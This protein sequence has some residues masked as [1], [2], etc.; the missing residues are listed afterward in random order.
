MA[1][2]LEALL[3]ASLK[4]SQTLETPQ[5]LGTSQTLESFQPLKERQDSNGSAS[6][7]DPNP[8]SNGSAK[9]D[10]S[11]RP[12]TND[13]SQPNQRLSTSQEDS[14]EYLDTGLN[15]EQRRAVG[16]SVNGPGDSEGSPVAL[17]HGPFGTGKTRTLVEVVRQRVK[18]GAQIQKEGT[19]LALF[20][21]VVCQ[22]RKNSTQYSVIPLAGCC[23][24]KTDPGKKSGCL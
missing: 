2:F 15:E 23:A 19:S 22:F 6:T 7:S 13:K 10:S 24:S 20:S 14:L 4:T 3:G 11:T 9:P 16:L 18:A 1:R 8:T 17:L 12:S 5:T 21:E